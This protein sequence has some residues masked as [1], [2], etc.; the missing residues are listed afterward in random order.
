MHPARKVLVRKNEW[1]RPSLTRFEV[2]E[3]EVAR[4]M[5]APSPETE[6]VKLY[7]ER[8]RQL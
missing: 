3:A 1:T 7:R 5:G 4:I 2:S 6:L 8:S